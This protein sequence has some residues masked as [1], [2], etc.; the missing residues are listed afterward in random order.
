M[1]KLLTLKGKVVNKGTKKGVPNLSVEAWDK[2]F[3]FDDYLGRAISDRDGSFTIIIDPNDFREFLFDNL[4][5]I[6][7]KVYSQR[8]LIKST[9]DN[10]VWNVKVEERIFLI[11]I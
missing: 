10:V 11:E 7:F 4:P 3:I 5:D 6:F 8:V 1:S 2:D 9:E